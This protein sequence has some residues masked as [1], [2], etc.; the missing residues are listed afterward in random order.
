MRSSKKILKKNL[1]KLSDLDFELFLLSLG[2]LGEIGD[3]AEPPA[4]ILHYGDR[5][6]PSPLSRFRRVLGLHLEVLQHILHC[7]PQISQ[8]R[9]SE[10]SKR[11]REIRKKGASGGNQT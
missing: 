8:N 9:F 11:E 3:H 5:L 1:C 4:G 2:A 6:P 10:F 7:F